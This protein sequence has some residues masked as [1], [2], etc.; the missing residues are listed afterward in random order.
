WS[1]GFD[2]R[3]VL[4]VWV[5]RPDNGAVPGL[6]GYGAAAPILFEGFAKAGIAITPLPGPPAGAVRLVQADLPISQRRFSVTANGLLSASVREAAPQIVFP[7][8]G[9]RVELGAQGDGVITP[10]TLKLQGGRA[11]FRWLANGRPLPD[12]ARRRVSQWQPDGGGYSTL[13]VI[14]AL[15]RAASVRVFVQ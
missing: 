6:T 8:E 15:G 7:P 10:L 2:G 9:A 11:P 14:D 4:G 13:T 1:V 3:Y 12:V 5:G